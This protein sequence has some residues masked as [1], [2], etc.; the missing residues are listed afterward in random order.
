M[1]LPDLRGAV[2][3]LLQS[4]R[5]LEPLKELFWSCLN[6]ERVNQPLSRRGWSEAAAQALAEDPALF[7][8]GGQDGAFHIIYGRLV[9]DKLFLTP[10][11]L[12][13]SRLLQDHPYAL[14]GFSSN[15]QDRWHFLNVKYDERRD[16]RRLFRRI[17]VGPEERLRTACERLSMLDLESFGFFTVAPLE[18]QERHDEA[19]D[20]EAV[21]ARF[22]QDYK[23][24]FSRLEADLTKQTK[25]RGWA[26]DYA[27]QFLNRCMFLYF[28]QRKRWLG[29]DIR[30]L[31]SFWGSYK[32]A[33]A[34]P[35]TFFDLWLKVLFFEAFNNKFHGGHRHFP[36]VIQETLA[37]APYLNGGLFEENELDRKHDFT[38]RDAPFEEISEFLQGYNFTIREDS[39]LDQEVAVD[40]EMI[41]KVYESLVNVSEEANE[42]GDA[43]I[44][45]TPRIEI[46]LMCRLALVDNLANHLG[47]QRKHL[48]YELVFAL[49]PEEKQ[50]ANDAAGRA[51]LWSELDARLRALTVLDPACGSG[52]FLVGFLHVLDD[53][54]A[55][56]AGRLGRTESPYERQ[57]RIIGQSLYG[58][59]V[60]DWAV[61]VAELRLWLALIIEADFTREDLHLRNEPL[62][63]RL[64]FKVRCGDSLLQDVGGVNLGSLRTSRQIPASLKARITKLKTEKLK[65]YNDDPT[66]SFRSASQVTQEELR[67][68]REILDSRRHA[69]V[70]EVKTLRRRIEQ[71]PAAQIRLDGT[72]EAKPSQMQLHAIEWQRQAEASG[73]E[74]ERVERARSALRSGKDVPFVWDIAFVEVFEGDAGGVDIVIGNPPYVRQESISDPLLSREAVTNQNKKE[75]KEKLARSVYEAYPHF[76]GYKA[77]TETAVHRLD[78]KSDLY[79]YFYFHGL[80]L[81]NPRGS[82]CFIASD[83]WLDVGYGSDL[84][85]F[86][87]NHA[88]VKMILDNRAKRSF[89]SADVN[90][91][92]VLLSS[93][94]DTRPWG[95]EQT[96]RFVVVKVPFE[97]VISPVIFEEIEAAS[98]RKVTPEY[99]VFPV[100]QKLLFSRGR[101][102]AKA[103]ETDGRRAAVESGPYIGGKWSAKYLRAPDVYWEVLERNHDRLV[104]LGDIADVRFGIKTGANE[105]FYLDKARVREWGIERRFLRPV[106]LRP[107]DIRTPEIRAEDLDTFLLIADQPRRK[108]K[109]TDVEGYIRWGE[110]QGFHR[111]ATCAARGGDWYRLSAR[112]PP[113]LILPIRNKMKLV[114]GL[115]TCGAQVDNT[116]L[117]VR[118]DQSFGHDVL[119]PLLLATFAFIARH[120]EGRSYGRMLEV[121]TYEAALLTLYDPRKLPPPE[122]DHLLSAF[123]RI[124]SQPFD[125]LVREMETPDREAFDRVW[126]SIHGY[127]TAAEQD[128][129]LR[130]IRD[131]VRRISNEMNAQEQAWVKDR[132]AA[133]A[134][135]NPQDYMKGKRTRAPNETEDDE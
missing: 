122:V 83:K 52:S 91:V 123:E 131:A 4:L 124:R 85:E 40:P 68:F 107:A 34:P 64:N 36:S 118:P 29:D 133:R 3:S 120:A 5:G 92:I 35:D 109:G 42:R 1:T 12:V 110:K 6:Y 24:A 128:A 125:W 56:A 47:E 27:L 63:P 134:G 57:R 17:T 116:C 62:L 88:G 23:A 106:I 80:S 129:A 111:T 45:Y 72:V 59:D 103:A 95:L 37:L 100:S 81:L 66:C 31:E 114:L 75:Y 87:L 21:T 51:G 86:L 119:A 113:A 61:R 76:F 82:F 44:F 26:H 20:V 89:R 39:P 135:G 112:Q 115:N 79:V 105:F 132:P 30:F 70:E 94:D 10:E 14:F 121:R 96:A 130:A 98:Q 53:L 55:R 65:F 41:G 102:V 117:E 97:H 101:Q 73:E 74:L 69:L 38:V 90:T 84:Q 13:V 28:I 46:E 99:R 60:M 2:L 32:M 48:L 25:D 49:E 8:A 50:A 18:I 77:A 22:F 71:R 15:G 19:F 54:Q 126:L 58:V 108:L 78:A 67:I 9:S 104:R 93:P 43:G 127:R 33:G 7:A 16:K 11:R